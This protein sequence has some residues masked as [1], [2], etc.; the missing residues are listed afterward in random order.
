M[1]LIDRRKVNDF[2]QQKAIV[3]MVNTSILVRIIS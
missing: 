3:G 2:D 1:I